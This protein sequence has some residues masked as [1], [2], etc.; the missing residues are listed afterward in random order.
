MD[1]TFVGTFTRMAFKD[2]SQGIKI[3]ISRSI[4][5][6]FESYM[7]GINWTEDKFNMQNFVA[8]WGEYII[9]HASWYSQ[10]SEETK[11][12]SEFHEQLAVKINEVINKILSEKPSQAQMEEIS[13]LQ[14]QLGEEYDYSC[15]I[16]A[17]YI[18]EQMKEKLKK[19]RQA[20][21]CR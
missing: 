2:L 3:S 18:I 14:E 10:I 7:N 16:E 12:D 9:N 20:N 8:E 11:A 4:T 13:E 5:T 6:S 15:K 1:L 19:N 17:K 21:A